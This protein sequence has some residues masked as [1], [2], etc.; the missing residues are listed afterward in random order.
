MGR[1]S[2]EKNKKEKLE[3][4][5]G[6]IFGPSIYEE[7]KESESYEDF[8]E[9]AIEKFR[10]EIKELEDSKKEWYDKVTLKVRMSWEKERSARTYYADKAL[11]KE[12]RSG[13]LSKRD[14]WKIYD[15][16]GLSEEEIRE[17]IKKVEEERKE[18]K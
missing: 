3:T 1:E 11:R 14:A 18:K 7:K 12:L 13:T 4:V 2:L 10:K 17:R 15:R 16:V 9:R 6:D 8:I 5:P